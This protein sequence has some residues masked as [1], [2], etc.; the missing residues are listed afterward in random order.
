MEWSLPLKQNKEFL[1]PAFCIPELALSAFPGLGAD[2]FDRFWHLP[3]DLVL[4]NFP[5]GDV[6]GAQMRCVVNQRTTQ[7]AAARVEL[8]DTTR[9]EVDKDVWVADL[10]GSLLA[11][12]CVHNL[13]RKNEPAII[14]APAIYAIRKIELLGESLFDA[15]FP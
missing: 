4:K 6:R 5:E 15:I 12:F 7:A 2:Q 11:Q 8:A 14:P 1:H 13:G 9:D 3:A 10:F